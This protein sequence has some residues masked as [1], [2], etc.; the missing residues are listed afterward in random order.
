VDCLKKLQGHIFGVHLKDIV[1]FNNVKARD[2]TVGHGVV[3]FPAVFAELKRQGF[4]GMLSIEQESN[5]YHNV[6]DVINT[7]KYFEEQVAKWK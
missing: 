5:W 7:R 3:D 6:P 1:E 4:S 2:T